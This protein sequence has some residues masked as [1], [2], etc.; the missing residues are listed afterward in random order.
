MTDKPVLEVDKVGL[1]FSGR[2]ILDGVSFEIHG[3]E[4]TG[5]IGSNGVGKT[6]LLRIILGPQQ[7][8]SGEVRVLGAPLSPKSIPGLRSPE[9]G[10][11]SRHTDAGTGLRGAWSRRSS[12]RLCPKNCSPA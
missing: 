5:L 3:G 10:N 9:S 4:F 2:R 7:P 11:R 1:S 8:D 6:T 12:L